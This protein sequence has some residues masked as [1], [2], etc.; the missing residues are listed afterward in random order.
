MKVCGWATVCSGS[1]TPPSAHFFNAEVMIQA[2]GFPGGSSSQESSCQ[3]RRC[4]R[5]GFD[6]WVGKIPW[7]RKWQPSSLSWRLPWREE[8]GGLPST[9]LQ[10]R[11]RLSTHARV[12][13]I[14]WLPCGGW[15]IIRPIR[16]SE[17]SHSTAAGKSQCVQRQLLLTNGCLKVGWTIY[18]G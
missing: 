16:F 1:V 4:K 10:S 9:G 2:W 6:P 7:S 11:I 8:P 3:C 13:Q 5:L 18:P 15:F 17:A 12:I 14:L